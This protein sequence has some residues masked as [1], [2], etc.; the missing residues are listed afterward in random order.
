MNIAEIKGRT[1][2][3]SEGYVVLPEDYVKLIEGIAERG[4][5]IKQQEEII[6]NHAKEIDTWKERYF[7]LIEHHR[8]YFIEQ[9][10]ESLKALSELN[11]Q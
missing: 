2:M 11:K 4:L 1:N 10:K 8:D 6:I 5:K 7:N 9:S 3:C